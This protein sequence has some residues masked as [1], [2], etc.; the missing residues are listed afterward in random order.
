MGLRNALRMELSKALV[1]PSC[2]STATL[3]KAPTRATAATARSTAVFGRLRRRGALVVVIG[4]S[5][6]ELSV[7]LAS[8][9]ASSEPST[10][11]RFVKS[12]DGHR[13][14]G[15]PKPVTAVGQ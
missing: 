2:I 15:L 7:D 8:G 11:Y 9:I 6:F 10:P 12:L 3:P 1:S 13:P 5:V 14:E 4:A